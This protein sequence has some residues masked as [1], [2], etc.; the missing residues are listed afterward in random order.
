MRLLYHDKKM[1]R[2][3]LFGLMIILFSGLVQSIGIAPA[4]K[5]LVVAPGTSEDIEYRIYNTESKDF[6]VS[7]SVEGEL[8]EYVV[9]EPADLD[10]SRSDAVKR[11]TLKIDIPDSDLL[12]SNLKISILET[13]ETAEPSMKLSANLDLSMATGN[14][15]GEPEEEPGQDYGESQEKKAGDKELKT[16]TLGRKKPNLL[17]LGSLILI[18]VI[19][20][21]ILWF[22]LV[23]GRSAPSIQPQDVA[24]E[25]KLSE[26]YA[27]LVDE[28]WS[29]QKKEKIKS[30]I[31]DEKAD[32]SDASGTQDSASP[33]AE[34]DISAYDQEDLREASKLQEEF[35]NE[36]Q[37]SQK[38]RTDQGQEMRQDDRH[39]ES[40]KDAI[41]GIQERVCPKN[42][43]DNDNLQPLRLE[44][45]K[46]I[47]SVSGLLDWLRSV[48]DET[49]SAHVHNEKDDFSSWVYHILKEKDLG[50]RLYQTRSRNDAI[51]IIEEH[52]KQNEDFDKQHADQLKKEMDSIGRDF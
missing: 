12:P 36:Q 46:E 35:D 38:V 40:L 51:R 18:A 6:S 3:W 15:V 33:E 52:M 45:D 49:Y 2:M 25:M 14:V 29:E 34:K 43:E 31:S 41:A 23:R 20:V 21:N 17:L 13:E 24:S 37:E 9:V 5:D 27:D 1:K 26:E 30:D 11:F 16:A 10:F 8:S 44:G 28:S 47:D 4:N 7:I 48:D 42:V 19:I 50:M 22:T 39:K 32:D